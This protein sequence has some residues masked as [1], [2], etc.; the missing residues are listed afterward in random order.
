MYA[1]QQN[2]EGTNI[3]WEEVEDPKLESGYAILRVSAAGVNRADILQRKGLYPPPKGASEI[4]GLE[5]AGT[6]E[7]LASNGAHHQWKEGERVM[8]LIPGGAYA[9]KVA[10][11]ISLL[12]PIPDA[13]S[14][15]EAAAIPEALY[16]AYLNLILEA[17]LQQ[18]E[19]LLIHAAA[20][21]IGS[22]AVQIAKLYGAYVVGTVGTDQKAQFIRELGA[23]HALNYKDGNLKERLQE[24]APGGYH[25]ILDPIGSPD[26]TKMHENLI[27]YK[28]RW[29]LIGLLGG[30]KV[31][32]NL[33]KVLTKNVML[34]GSTLRNKPLEA[35]IELTQKIRDSVL[36]YYQTGDLKPVLDQYFPIQE[37]EKA[38]HYM[39]SNKAMGKVVLEVD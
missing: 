22:T 15:S 19:T 14:F 17:E 4:L 25:L 39:Q 9:E 1:I 35:K 18:G 37:A 26:Y 31:E 28:G 8:A 2:K 30:M 7:Q 12:L 6:I 16:T 13:L 33:A 29:L 27:N 21:G 34:K 10:V 32:L 38:H 11:P 36:N 20:G 23:H 24:V 5:V 3:S